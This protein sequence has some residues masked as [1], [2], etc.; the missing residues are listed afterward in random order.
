[1]LLVIVFNDVGAPFMTLMFEGL[2][3]SPVAGLQQIQALVPSPLVHPLKTRLQHSSNQEAASLLLS[4]G[5]S[6]H[7]QLVKAFNMNISVFKPGKLYLITRKKNFNWQLYMAP[8]YHIVMVR[9]YY[10][11]HI[12]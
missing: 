6:K 9:V 8:I 5:L 7:K 2:P 12:S 11:I 4:L 1:M 3:T 10:Y